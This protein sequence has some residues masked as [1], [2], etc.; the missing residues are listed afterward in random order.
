VKHDSAQGIFS[1]REDL[2]EQIHHNGGKLPKGMFIDGDGVK[3]DS[4]NKIE[5]LQSDFQSWGGFAK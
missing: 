4:P 1:S 5:F 2:C 3:I